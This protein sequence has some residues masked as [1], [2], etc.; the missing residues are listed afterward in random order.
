MVKT[1]ISNL[2]SSLLPNAENLVKDKVIKIEFNPAD[3]LPEIFIDKNRISQVLINLLTNAVKFTE[4][5]KIT[6]STSLEKLPNKQKVVMV[7]IKDSGIGINKK[8]Q[9]KLFKPF[10]Q[11][12]SQENSRTFGSGLGLAIS[13]SIIELH[14]GQIGLL[15]SI[16]GGGSTFYFILP[17]E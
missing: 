4:Y 3:D 7:K 16:P 12:Q 1:N 17:I 11:A 6:I 5:G 8:D 9:E 14:K 15:E 2:I 10:S 13:K